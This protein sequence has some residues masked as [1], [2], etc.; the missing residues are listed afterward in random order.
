[1]EEKSYL[2]S[3]V[4]V[5]QFA[6]PGYL[7]HMGNMHG[8]EIMKLMDNTAGLT[9][10]RHAG[11][12]AVTA[13]VNNLRL[14][15]PIRENDAVKCTSELIA[16]GRSSMEAFVE[17]FVEN[18]ETG[19]CIKVAE[20]L[21]VGVGVDDEGK[22]RPVASLKIETSLQRERQKQKEQDTK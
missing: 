5:I 11:G 6:L 2:K 9:F 8:G 3:K 10:L 21:F 13:A 14:I 17:V 7:N 16:T 1:M 4:E 15:K 18:L 22:A 12:K 20:A 19:E